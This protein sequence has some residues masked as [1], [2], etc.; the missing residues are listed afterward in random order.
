MKPLKALCI[1]TRW[2]LSSTHGRPQPQ[3]AF[4]IPSISLPLLKGSACA[5]VSRSDL[6]TGTAPARGSVWMAAERG[7]LP[8]QCQAPSRREGVRGGSRVSDHGALDRLGPGQGSA[9]CSMRSQERGRGRGTGSTGGLPLCTSS[10]AHR[11][12]TV[13]A[14][15]PLCLGSRTAGT[16]LPLRRRGG[17][18]GVYSCRGFQH[19]PQKHLENDEFPRDWGDSGLSSGTSFGS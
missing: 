1:G 14:R 10:G 17:N 5:A 12:L 19:P 16:P 18:L 9:Q 2:E 3:W 11:P 8:W 13:A 4:A 15:F 7:Q 6:H